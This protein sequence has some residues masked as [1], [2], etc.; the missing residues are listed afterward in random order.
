MTPVVEA[1][2]PSATSLSAYG[3]ARSTIQG[4]PLSR[5]ELRKTD[6]Y[7]RASLYL[8]LGMVYSRTTPC[9]VSRSRS[10]MSSHACWVT[11]ARMPA[12]PSLTSISTG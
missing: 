10:S 3:Q 5:E 6:A 8:C 11:G 2:V 12:K 1:E 4:S 7:W 9:F